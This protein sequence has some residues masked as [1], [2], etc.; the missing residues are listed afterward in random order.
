MNETELELKIPGSL[1]SALGLINKPAKP[2]VCLFRVPTVAATATTNNSFSTYSTSSTS[3]TCSIS[4]T[5]FT[6]LKLR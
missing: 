1:P 2:C 4:S 3:S 5:I 6:V